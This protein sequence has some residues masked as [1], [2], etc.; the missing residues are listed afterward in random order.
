[1]DGVMNERT[2]NVSTFSQINC[3]SRE[4]FNEKVAMRR[5]SRAD[6]CNQAQ[7]IPNHRNRT[8]RVEDFGMLV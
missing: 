6:I 4:R 2:I 3:L 7:A 8:L 5:W 1:M